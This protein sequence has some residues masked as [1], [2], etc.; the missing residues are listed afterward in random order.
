MGLGS[1]NQ[2][3]QVLYISPIAAGRM[4]VVPT[5]WRPHLRA[6][7]GSLVS[8]PAKSRLMPTTSRLAVSTHPQSREAGHRRR[9]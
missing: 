5:A 4:R 8:N 1:V 7:I 9:L 3:Q 6:A 2:P